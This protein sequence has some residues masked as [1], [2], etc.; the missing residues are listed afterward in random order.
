[1]IITFYIGVSDATTCLNKIL[2]K[3]FIHFAYFVPCFKFGMGTYLPV[4][5]ENTSKTGSRN[6]SEKNRQRHVEMFETSNFQFP[7]FPKN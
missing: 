6:F 5:I 1:M 7:S 2:L 3:C 4:G